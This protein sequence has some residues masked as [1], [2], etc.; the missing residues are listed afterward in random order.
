M[1]KYLFILILLLPMNAQAADEWTKKDSVIQG[2][3]YIFHFIDWRQTRYITK[4]SQWYE[5][6]PILG[7]YPS[8]NTVDGYFL[9]TTILH[10]AV[11]YY[12]PQPYRGWWQ[13]VWIFGSATCVFH[14][15]SVGIKMDL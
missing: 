13:G 14:N 2:T 5:M 1:P 10:T 9:I 12:L 11:A 6:N 8:T 4:N 15:F 7:K 3:Y